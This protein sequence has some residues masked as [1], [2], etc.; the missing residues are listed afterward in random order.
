MAGKKKQSSEETEIVPVEEADEIEAAP[1][2]GLPTQAEIDAALRDIA[3]GTSKRTH[4]IKEKVDDDG[5]GNKERQLKEA[6][7]DPPDVN[8][9]LRLSADRIGGP[10]DYC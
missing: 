4:E 2:S 9:L 5:Y 10:Q 3:L 1:V 8:L 7:T 6:F